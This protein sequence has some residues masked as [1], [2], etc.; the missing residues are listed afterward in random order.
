MP[1]VSKRIAERIADDFGTSAPQV[2]SA[3][4][5]LDL[6]HEADPERV[7]AAVTLV[8]KGN[9]VMFDDALEHAREDWR[10]LLTRA[11]LETDGWRAKLD[12]ELGLDEH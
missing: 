9:R 7:H 3:L 12:Y 6:S 11:R 8:A 4:E 1:V 10:D 2:M 5:R